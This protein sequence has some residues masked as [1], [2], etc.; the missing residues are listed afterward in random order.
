MPNET[1]KVGLH[2]GGIVPLQERLPC[3]RPTHLRGS[4]QRAVHQP[5]GPQMAF[6][7]GLLVLQASIPLSSKVLNGQC[8]FPSF[9]ASFFNGGSK[10]LSTGLLFL[11]GR[12]QSFIH[13]GMSG[14]SSR[15][16]SKLDKLLILDDL[17]RL[18]VS[19]VPC[20]PLHFLLGSRLKCKIIRSS[21]VSRA[22]KIPAHHQQQKQQQQQR[23]RAFSTNPACS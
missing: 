4:P 6:V 18:L 7:P 17:P 16:H 9:L 23:K 19:P 3:T 10:Q 2:G 1:G 5:P 14:L 20:S 22:S 8:H 11:E 21:S 12:P 13:R 15:H